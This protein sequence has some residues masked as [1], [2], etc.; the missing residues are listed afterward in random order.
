MSAFVRSFVRASCLFMTA[1]LIACGD[2]NG[3]SEPAGPEVRILDTVRAGGFINVRTRGVTLSQVQYDASLGNASLVLAR[4]DDSTLVALVPDMPAGSYDLQASIGGEAISESVSVAAAIAVADPIG[5]AEQQFDAVIASYP[6]TPPSGI[7]QSDWDAQRDSLLS[8]IDQARTALAGMTAEEQ[9]ATARFMIALEDALSP[10]LVSGGPASLLSYV[11]AGS[12]SFACTQAAG[13]AFISGTAWL[14]GVGAFVAGVF[15]PG[16]GLIAAPVGAIVVWKAHPHMVADVQR[17]MAVC[18]EQQAIG[19]SSSSPGPVASSFSLASLEDFAPKAAGTL[20]GTANA[21][22]HTQGLGGVV[23]AEAALPAVNVAG[24]ANAVDAA[25]ATGAARMIFVRER[26][27]STQPTQDV[28]PFSTSHI[29]DNTQYSL[30]SSLL[31]KA[32][33]LYDELPAFVQRRLPSMPRLVTAG[34]KPIERTSFGPDSVQIANV[35]GGVSLSR[36]IDGASL[37]LTADAPGDNEREFTFEIVSAADA[38]VRDTVAALLVA[39][40][41]TLIPVADVWDATVT[42]DEA[43]QTWTMRCDMRWSVVIT[44][45][46]PV[47]LSSMTW[48]NH[49]PNSSFPSYPGSE[50]YP[51]NSYGPGTVVLYGYWYRT[52]GI[53]ENSADF[54]VT[55][56]MGYT[57]NVTGESGTTNNVDMICRLPPG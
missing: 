10:L 56:N 5:Y 22:G 45:T 42:T 11:Q 9:L 54:V 55:M 48:N 1:L 29:A 23:T 7:S 30:I 32:Y 18:Y 20:K 17:M 50:Q 4:M 41:V 37:V 51:P 33:S 49:V 21:V 26:P 47:H 19:L 27:V 16:I 8:A 24:S 53:G 28:Q 52:W 35:T 13:S 36:T 15:V 31:E 2:G 12:A 46:D 6:D 43:S 34:E 38:S 39:E 25:N 40:G 57:N 44:G 14:V 3:P